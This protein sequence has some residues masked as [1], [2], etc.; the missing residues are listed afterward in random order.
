MN[1]SMRPTEHAPRFHPL[2]LAAAVLVGLLA[3]PL[4]LAQDS[5]NGIER[6][7]TP[8]QSTAAGLDRLS[9]EQ[10]ANLNAWL[11]RTLVVEP[12]KAAQTAKQ[13][14][15]AAQA[16]APQAEDDRGFL[17]FGSSDDVVSRIVGRFDGFGEGRV[18]TLENGQVWGQTNN[19]NLA[20]VTLDNPT[21]EISSGM[22]GA[23]YMRVEG[24]NTRAKVE[25]IE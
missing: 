7:M 5:D 6:Q 23:W 13:E 2:V 1:R 17:D 22:F 20:G 18:Y 11:N 25:R 19:A 9:A 12:A 10:L 8:E 15:V 3:A 14:A 24:Y 21:V 16:A 4:A